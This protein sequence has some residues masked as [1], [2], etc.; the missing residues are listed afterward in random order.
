L[1]LYVVRHAVAFDYDPSQW[2][3]DSQRPLTPDGI[4]RF[5]RAALGLKELASSVELVLSS[6]WVRAWQTAEILE[7]ETGWPRPVACNA[8][9]SGH[10]PAEVLQALQPFTSYNAIAL[11]GHE[12]DLHELISYLLTADTT[13][14]QVE[15]KK[16]SVARLA[17]GEG[18]RPGSARLHWLLPPKALRA[19]GS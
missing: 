12:P 4:K 8:L 10:A 13:H 9:G 19:L 1:D 11:V 18:L 17:V 14:A 7:T 16:G 3:D 2:P 15:V 5:K 6:P